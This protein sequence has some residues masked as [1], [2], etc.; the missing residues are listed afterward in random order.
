VRRGRH[1]GQVEGERHPAAKLSVIDVS[2]A[3]L[4]A[5][6]RSHYR[7]WILELATARGVAES[8]A[9]M[10]IG[11][12]TWKCI[13]DPPAVPPRMRH[14]PRGRA[15]GTRPKC[16]RCRHAKYYAVHNGKPC[17]HR[18]HSIDHRQFTSR[19]NLRQRSA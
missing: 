3:R 7:G 14:N 19:L 13:E 1:A 16:P 9:V 10:A 5:A 11:G 18:F 4:I 15:G 6:D 17:H 8:T 12:R 2:L